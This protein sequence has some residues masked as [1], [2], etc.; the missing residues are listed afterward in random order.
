MLVNSGDLITGCFYFLPWDFFCNI[1]ILFFS[2]QIW[3]KKIRF[4][5]IKKVDNISSLDCKPE[6][7]AEHSW[8]FAIDTNSF[9]SF[10][11]HSYHY[12]AFF[13]KWDDEMERL[14]P[15]QAWSR[16]KVECQSGQLQIRKSCHRKQDLY[17]ILSLCHLLISYH[18]S[19]I[20]HTVI[21]LSGLQALWRGRHF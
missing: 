6:L 15:H 1:W 5:K 17:K 11:W 20:I 14:S 18:I 9:P 16:R 4:L 13:P 10:L 7:S 2:F 3:R 19:K 12:R 8:V 21:P